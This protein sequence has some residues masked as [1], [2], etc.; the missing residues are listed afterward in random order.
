MNSSPVYLQGR[1][2]FMSQFAI[3]IGILL[4]Q[5]VGLMFSYYDHWRYIFLFGAILNAINLIL[6]VGTSE[7]PKWLAS[8]GRLCASPHL[9]GIYS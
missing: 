9:S 7:S 8:S 4:A 6:L 1:M 3:N 2:G 5:V